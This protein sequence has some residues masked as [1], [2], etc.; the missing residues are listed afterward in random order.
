M[1]EIFPKNL[2]SGTV[3]N[4]D[5]L[6]RIF[7][8]NPSLSKKY[9]QIATYWTETRKW[10]EDNWPKVQKY[11]DKGFLNK[12]KMESEHDA[13]SW[14]FQLASVFIN[15][16]LNLIEKTWDYG[17]DF[18]IQLR[19][20]KKIWVEAIICTLGDTDPVEPRPILA[21]GMIHSFGGNVEE[22][23]RPRALRITNAIGSK[24]E[25]FKKYIEDPDCLVS[26]D[27]CLV[28]A[29]NGKLIQHHSDPFRL[30]KYAVFGQGPD[31]L[32]KIKGEDKLQS[33]FYKP[34]STIKRNSIKGETEIPV[35]FMDMEEFSQISAVLYCGHSESDSL[36]NEKR[37][38]DDFFF[39]YHTDPINS[40]PSDTFKFGIGVT[41]DIKTNS[42]TDHIQ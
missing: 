28:I 24:F 7:D 40:I 30:F 17:P 19:D 41:K 26:I 1:N 25:I 31:V 8:D 13:R 12:F 29:I 27:D 21:P 16:G 2:I 32:R 5:D 10:Y 9:L 38:G 33:G 15:E 37:I 18:C 22:I 3:K 34:V 23:N 39:A 6:D 4:Q 42:I 20:G 36:W 35:T 14:E 11:L